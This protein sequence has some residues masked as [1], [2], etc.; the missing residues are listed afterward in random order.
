M[1]KRYIIALCVFFMVG[2]FF[3]PSGL[4]EE[5][6]LSTRLKLIAQFGGMDVPEEQILNNPNDI[7]IS[8]EGFIYILDSNDNNIKI[9]TEEGDFVDCIGRWGQGPGEFDRPWALSI[10]KGFLYVADAKNKR[11][12]VL[13][14]EGE[15][16]RSYKVPVEYGRGIAFDSDGNVYLNTQGF[17]SPKLISVYDSQGEKTEQIGKLEG[18]S[19]KGYDF[20]LIKKQIKQKKIPEHLKNDLL[21]IIHKNNILWAIHRSLDKF[22]KFSIKGELLSEHQIKAK[23]YQSIYQTFLEK[24]KSEKRQSAYWPLCY[25]N[26]LALDKDGSL[27]ILLNEPSV[28]TIYVYD[29]K[30]RFKRKLIGV[31]D[32]IYRIALSERGYL[33]ALSRETQYIYKFQLDL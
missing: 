32:N 21:L 18:H 12:Q 1:K 31:K 20:L 14:K 25:V 30:G 9:F 24:N 7:A 26:D 19:I 10:L 15:Y 22:K 11:V 13:T 6:P 8:E 16:I 27:Y 33:Y 29:H 23:E 5:K 28:M 2:L 3:C 17:R 4:S